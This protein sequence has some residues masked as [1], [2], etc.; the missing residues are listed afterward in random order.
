LCVNIV[1]GDNFPRVPLVTARQYIRL[2]LLQHCKLLATG[3]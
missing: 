3:V 1:S 2:F